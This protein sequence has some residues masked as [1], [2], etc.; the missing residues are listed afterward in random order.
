MLIRRLFLVAFRQARASAKTMTNLLRHSF[1]LGLHGAHTMHN[2]G[3]FGVDLSSQNRTPKLPAGEAW[4]LKK[5]L[6]SEWLSLFQE[7]AA[8][9]TRVVFSVSPE[10]VRVKYPGSTFGQF[11]HVISELLFIPFVG[12]DGS[13]EITGLV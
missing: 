2:C 10:R 1:G 8:D 7:F 13:V 5:P 9:R 3:L 4:Q 11:T 6:L 12:D